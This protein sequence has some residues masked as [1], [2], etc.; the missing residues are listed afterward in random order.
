MTREISHNYLWCLI[1][2]PVEN[3]T[4]DLINDLT[5]AKIYSWMQI[6]KCGDIFDWGTDEAP[7]IIVRYFTGHSKYFVEDVSAGN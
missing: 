7:K 6:T 3:V 5:D 2:S 4:N 1:R